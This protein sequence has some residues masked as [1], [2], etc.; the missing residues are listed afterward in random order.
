MG[1]ATS[2]SKTSVH[3]RARFH[4]KVSR[5]IT[6]I[7]L[8]VRAYYAF[9]VRQTAKLRENGMVSFAVSSR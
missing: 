6:N 7:M 1:K 2:K 9:H 4:N 3:H 8:P 5:A